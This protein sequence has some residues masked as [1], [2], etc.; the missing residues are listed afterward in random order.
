MPL[1]QRNPK[2]KKNWRQVLNRQVRHEKTAP[3]SWM[4]KQPWFYGWLKS[5]AAKKEEA[6]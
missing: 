6:A 4:V 3:R 5:L 2:R 1:S